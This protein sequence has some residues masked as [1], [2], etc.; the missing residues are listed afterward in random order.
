ML[1]HRALALPHPP[2][3]AGCGATARRASGM[4]AACGVRGAAGSGT[5]ALGPHRRLQASP[6]STLCTQFPAKPSPPPHLQ[7]EAAVRQPFGPHTSLH[8]LPSNRSRAPTTPSR[9]PIRPSPPSTSFRSASSSVKPSRDRIISSMRWNTLRAG[10]QE[11][12]HAGVRVSCAEVQFIGRFQ[13]LKQTR[14][15]TPAQGVLGDVVGRRG[16]QPR[17]A[18]RLAGAAQ[19]YLAGLAGPLAYALLCNHPLPSARPVLFARPCRCC[20]PPTCFRLSS[21]R[22]SWK[23]GCRRSSVGIRREQNRATSA[24]DARHERRDRC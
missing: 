7:Q 18:A 2:A 5:A 16:P 20:W 4:G 6:P 14:G 19:R 11:C 9:P 10:R 1:H 17:H 22:P 12:R 13:P 8:P 21:Y 23:A 3:R 24:G 15:F